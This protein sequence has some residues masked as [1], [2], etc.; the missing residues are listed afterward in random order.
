[1]PAPPDGRLI[2]RRTALKALL[3]VG[4]GAFTGSAVYGC[5]WARHRIEV[6]RTELGVSGL[7]EAL[8]GLSIALLTDFH[9][10][11]T[12][13]SGDIAR[14]VQLANDAHPDLV[15]L[16]GD[17]VTL[18]DRDYIDEA[19]DLVGAVRGRHGAY[20][21]LG[22]HDGDRDMTTALER[23]SIDVLRDDRTSLRVNGERLDLV[24]IRYWT[25]R[26]AEIGRLLDARAPATILLAHDPRRFTEAAAL[27]VPLVLSGH[28]HGGQVVVPGLGAPAARR[29][30]VLA[31]AAR[32]GQTTL[33]VSRGIGT[34]YLPV[35]LNCP[36]EVNLLTLRQA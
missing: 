17:Y 3:A 11:A 19:G 18:A 27:G 35:R 7:P 5:A 21:V 25:R 32:R 31:G 30:P 4:A 33:F 12:V 34:V 20:A 6:T 29:F 28:T 14:A 8:D 10:S 9:C 1:M 24:G 26:T 15:I 23:R 2:G 36:P 22:N 16:G 13:R